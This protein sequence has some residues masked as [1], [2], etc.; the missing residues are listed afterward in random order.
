MSMYV[1]SGSTF[2][3]LQSILDAHTA[4]Y[5]KSMDQLASGNKYPSVGDDP[6]LVCES[7]KLQVQIDANTKAADNVSIGKDM[8]SMA[9]EYQGNIMSQIQTIKD[10]CV[11]IA[12]GTYKDVDKDY[13]LKDIRTRLSYIDNTATS[14]NFNKLHLL[15]GSASNTFLQVGP[16]TNATM[17]VGSALIDVHPAALDI[18]L[19]PTINGANWSLTD[20]ETYMDKLDSA[21][22]TLLGTRAQLGGY[23]N[24]LDALS[25]ILTNMNDNL[26]NNKS[27]I[28]DT[29]TAETSADMVRYQIL[30]QASASILA[31]ANQVPTWALQLL[32]HF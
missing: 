19:D 4:L 32:N 11:Q 1:K 27:V 8:L 3:Y 28:S 24:R 10:D 22:T 5:Q 9:E 26:T 20:I 18:D 12:N 16:I 30:Q 14:T 25:G 7:A 29:D 13:I 6:M 15:D 21:T 2:T 31:Q 17:S 23:M